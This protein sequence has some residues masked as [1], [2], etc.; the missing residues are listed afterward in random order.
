M[1]LAIVMNLAPRKLGSFEGWIAAM[2]EEARGR[3]HEVDV[4]SRGPVHPGFARRLEECGAGWYRVEELLESA[5][6][7][8]RRLA[9]Y[10]VIH[11]NMFVPRSRMAMMALVDP[12]QYGDLKVLVQA[13]GIRLDARLLGFSSDAC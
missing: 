1:R 11:L 6:R 8:I 7:G 9:T 12:E 10:D 2:C 5:Y 13:K 4:Y 3:G